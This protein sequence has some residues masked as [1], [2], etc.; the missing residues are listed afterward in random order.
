MAPFFSIHTHTYNKNMY[1]QNTSEK[2]KYII[3]IKYVYKN[4]FLFK[5][6]F[7]TSA[8]NILAC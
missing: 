7:Y 4:V 2:K 3:S 1:S 6:S 5:I 8:K